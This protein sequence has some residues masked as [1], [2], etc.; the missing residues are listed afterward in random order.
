M[1]FFS[2]EDKATSLIDYSAKQT[3]PHMLIVVSYVEK[4]D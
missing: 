4:E 2:T 3:T 1:V